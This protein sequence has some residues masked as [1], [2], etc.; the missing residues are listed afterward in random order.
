MTQR[1][2]RIDMLPPEVQDQIVALRAKYVGGSG[3]VTTQQLER[4]ALAL[5]SGRLPTGKNWEASNIATA[6]GRIVLRYFSEYPE[7]KRTFTNYV[8][9]LKASG[10]AVDRPKGGRPSTNGHSEST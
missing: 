10:V 7:Q 2:I 4:A 5:N 9:R 3:I 6:L 1:T 8:T